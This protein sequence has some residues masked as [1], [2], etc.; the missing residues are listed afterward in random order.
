MISGYR[1]VESSSTRGRC[2]KY[3]PLACFELALRSLATDA[4]LKSV[5]IRSPLMYSERGI[6]I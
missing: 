5:T 1:G 4:S 2:L 6:E 3:S